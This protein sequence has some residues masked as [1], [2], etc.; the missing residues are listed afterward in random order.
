[1]SLGMFPFE[2]DA[3]VLLRLDILRR[4]MAT[5]VDG[6]GVLRSRVEPTVR[7]ENCRDVEFLASSMAM[8][9]QLRSSSVSKAA[10]STGKEKKSKEVSRA[11]ESN[12]GMDTAA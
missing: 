7:G 11:I 1:M 4:P 10:V 3:I 12:V 6:S 8:Q 9:S 5:A 2:F